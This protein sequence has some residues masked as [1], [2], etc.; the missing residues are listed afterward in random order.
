[1]SGKKG[2]S[3]GIAARDLSERLYQV[4]DVLCHLVSGKGHGLRTERV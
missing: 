2:R 1:M 3:G 4:V